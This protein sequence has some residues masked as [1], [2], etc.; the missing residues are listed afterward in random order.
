M[1][2]RRKA[3][4]CALQMMFAADFAKF[5]KDFSTTDYWRNFGF[6]QVRKGTSQRAKNYLEKI[7]S[8]EILIKKELKSVARKN[9][10]ISESIDYLLDLLS[11]VEISYRQMIEAAVESTEVWEKSKQK[12]S[13]AIAALRTEI[14]KVI[15]SLEQDIQQN[16]DNYSLLEIE[17]VNE[18]KEQIKHILNRMDINLRTLKK[19]IDIVF[20]VRQ[21]ADDL[22][23]ETINHINEIDELISRKAEHWRIYRMATVDRNIIRVAAFELLDGEIPETI[24]IN[25][26]IEIA[27]RFST[28]EATQFINGVLDAIKDELES[29]SKKTAMSQS[30]SSNEYVKSDADESF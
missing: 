19:T 23:L 27:R 26:A 10:R 20:A 1:G 30:A 12:A 29:S 13:E 16:E 11:R 5:P 17:L 4:E 7:T 18:S 8:L 6:D 15:S 21:Y 22:T 14:K 3:R 9:L 2:I 28:S 24:I 25:E